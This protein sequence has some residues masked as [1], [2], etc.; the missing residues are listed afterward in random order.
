MARRAYA[1]PAGGITASPVKMISREGAKR[2]ASDR[3]VHSLYDGA[4]FRNAG[5]TEP[6]RGKRDLFASSRE[7]KKSGGE[8][9]RSRTAGGLVE[10]GARL[11]LRLG[12]FIARHFARQEIGRA[13]V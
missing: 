3:Q 8:A 5:K 6:L 4:A 1:L 12:D 2:L 13:H 11:T 7:S 9:P 10:P